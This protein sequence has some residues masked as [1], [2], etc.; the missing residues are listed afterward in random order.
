MIKVMIKIVG[1]I[2]QHV[3]TDEKGHEIELIIVDVDKQST[4]PAKVTT[5]VA[6]VRRSIAAHVGETV[7]QS[8]ARR[9]DY[10]VFVTPKRGVPLFEFEG[11]LKGI[12]SEKDYQETYLTV[13]DKEGNSF[14]VGIDQVEFV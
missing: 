11:T 2:V 4:E 13:E 9:L 10:E 7:H 5:M 1:G 14:D 6:E 3:V 8:F 12:T